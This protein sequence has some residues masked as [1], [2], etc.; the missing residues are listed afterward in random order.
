ME[1][2]ANNQ[3]ITSRNSCF[4]GRAAEAVKQA[5]LTASA[6]QAYASAYK[7]TAIPSGDVKWYRVALAVATVAFLLHGCH[8]G[9]CEL[10]LVSTFLLEF[11][12]PV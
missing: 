10:S 3:Q 4:S 1:N 2:S 12:L 9:I 7:R 5:C 8:P 6:L 11:G